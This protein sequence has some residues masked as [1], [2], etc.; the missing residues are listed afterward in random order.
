M[1]FIINSAWQ[2]LSEFLQKENDIESQI[3]YNLPAEIAI[4]NTSGRYLFFNKSFIPDQKLADNVTNETDNFLYRNYYIDKDCL[5]KRTQAFEKMLQ[6]RETVRFT[7]KIKIETTGK[8][9]YYKRFYIPLFDEKNNLTKICFWGSNLTAIIH[10]QKELKYLAYHDK[11]TGLKN[12]SAFYEQIQQMIVEHDRKKDLTFSAVLFCDLDNF[13]TVNDT[14]G[15]DA[16][17]FVLKSTA[18]RMQSCLRQADQIFRIGGDEFIIL[19]KNVENGFDAG[20]VAEKVI[21][22]LS[23]PI[24]INQ[25]IVDYLTVSIGIALYPKDANHTDELISAAD[26]A[27]YKAK[28]KGK[29]NFQFAS[30]DTTRNI[31]QYLS[32][33]KSMRKM[34]NTNDFE[35]QLKVY[36]QPIVARKNNGH[37]KL[38]GLEALLRWYN[39]EVGFPE[40]DLFI[41]IAERIQLMNHLGEWIFL[42]A[43]KDFQSLKKQFSNLEYV[44]VN[45]SAQQLI[46]ND[47]C[48]LVQKICNTS[49]LNPQQ[50]Q[51]EI[52]E[53]LYMENKNREIEKLKS[54]KNLGCKLAIDD[55]GTGYSSL[56]QLQNIPVSTIKI[57]RSF[58]SDYIQNSS[59]EKLAK[60]IINLAKNLDKEIIAEGVESIEQLNFLR[61]QKCNF[62]QGFLFGEPVPLE[63]VIKFS[64]KELDRYVK[65]YDRL[66]HLKKQQDEIV[67]AS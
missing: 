44:S 38:V 39:D 55:F 62:Y 8:T 47:I 21:Q 15:H 58:I 27:M 46:S 64:E 53:S 61:K 40:P 43:A 9:K 5:E 32:M 10:A 26:T 51:L 22:V 14:L 54:L 20:F 31:L 37:L 65:N 50:I 25:T 34:V 57:D 60:S 18:Q 11:V 6:N 16:G 30:E 52:T 63:Q 3:L 41:G 7:E 12:R 36:Y 35:N 2:K 4:L 19:L 33:E 24:T 56:S 13:K 48:E 17:D 28:M 66:N 29:N 1:K 45:I 49:L 59:N 23:A 67:E 42:K